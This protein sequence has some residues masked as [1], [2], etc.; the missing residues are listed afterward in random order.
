MSHLGGGDDYPPLGYMIARS[1][2]WDGCGCLV[3]VFLATVAV[4]VGIGLFAQWHMDRVKQHEDPAPA[5]GRENPEH[6]PDAD[7]GPSP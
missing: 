2:Q 1:R 4:A 3:G 5:T 6:R 7:S